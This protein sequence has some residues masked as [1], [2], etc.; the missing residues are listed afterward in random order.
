MLFKK[1]YP[2]LDL[3]RAIAITLVML[4]HFKQQ[5]F[6]LPGTSHLARFFDWGLHGVDLF[7][8]LS[9]FLIGGQ[10]IERI[11]ERTFSFKEFYVKRLFRIAPAYY[12]ALI[13]SVIFYSVGTGSFILH[14]KRILNA[15]IV[16][17]FYLQD[18]TRAVIHR[19]LYWT[20]A[21]EEQFYI[22]IPALLFIFHGRR[23]S[24]LAGFL[25]LFILAGFSLKFILYD[26]TKDWSVYFYQ[27][28]HMRFDSL[29]LGV[30]AAYAFITYREKLRENAILC[31]IALYSVAAFCLVLTYLYGSFGHGYF[32]TTWMFILSG[33]GFA[34]LILA[35]AVFTNPRMRLHWFFKPIATFS[36][37]MYLYHTMIKTIFINYLVRFFSVNNTLVTNYLVTF[38]AYFAVVFI[39]CGMHYYVV[40][41]P[42]LKYR[43][44]LVSRMQ[45]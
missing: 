21:V 34:A 18:Y 16:H 2:E 42:C 14:D 13:I 6:H 38:V 5:T 20:L 10:L 29:L 39:L 40:E 24:R 33:I 11:Q 36:Y 26:P 35:M 22:L 44:K 37:A 1:N 4:V 12:M 17:I 25:I 15:F 19:G 41:S 23:K 7:F 30:L 31:R 45:G 27:P 3:L 9:G 43:K 8:V 32:N 28:L